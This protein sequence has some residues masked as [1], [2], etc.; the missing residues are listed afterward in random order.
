MPKKILIINKTQFG[1]HTDYLM[2]CE[3]LK[4]DFDITFI[5][6]DVGFKKVVIS[7][8]DVKYVSHKGPKLLRGIKFLIYSLFTIW[9]SKAVVFIHYFEKCELLKRFCPWRKMILD[10]RTLS[11][12][13]NEQIRKQYDSKIKYACKFFDFVTVISEGVRNKIELSIK[14]SSILPLGA[15][16]VSLEPKR[17]D[18][19]MNLLYV[20][21]LSGRN[22][23]QTI[24]GLHEYLKESKLTSV[25][26][27]IIGDGKELGNL[28]KL[29]EEK[30]LKQIVKFHGR[31]PYPEVKPFLDKCNIGVSFVPLTV[32]YDHQPVTKTYE[33]ILSGLVC[34][35]S[36]TAE[37]RKVIDDSNGILC[38]DNPSSFA[39]GL[40]T[41]RSRF[42]TFDSQ[43][44]RD[45]LIE[46]NWNSIVNKSL[47][48]I[49]KRF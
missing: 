19:A 11:I 14:E 17:F 45:S 2:Y 28:K 9:F 22:I 49:L 13:P 25:T 18:N 24:L 3:H 29:V 35:A 27:D 48:P 1:Y 5:C 21:T 31:I 16:P 15:H 10:I 26:Y 37:N 8:I 12:H 7:E 23:D 33:Y 47:K 6:F 42:S 30:G 43:E 36:N 39:Q 38:M 41:L 34:I 46:H 20:G 44:I 32:Y 40:I 4:D